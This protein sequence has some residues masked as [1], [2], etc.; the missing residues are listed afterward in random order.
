VDRS[1]E[2]GTVASFSVVATAS[3]A[4]LPTTDVYYQWQRQRPGGQW[5]LVPDAVGA[6]YALT[7]GLGDNGS[8]YRVRIYSPGATAT[9]AEVNLEVYHIN[10][11]PKYTC[12]PVPG[13]VEDSGAH[14]VPGAV[15][16]IVPHSIV[17]TPVTFT[18]AFNSMPAG[19]IPS[20]T[21][22]PAIGPEG[23]L[24]LTD[25]INSQ[26]NFWTIPLAAARDFES[27]HAN[28]RLLI[29]GVGG[30]DGVSFNAGVDVGTSFTP[31]DGALNG[32]SVQVD[33]YNN[34]T[35]D[36]GVEVKWNGNRIAFL[37]VGAGIDGSGAPPELALARFVD[38]SV[39]VTATGEVTFRYDTYTLTAQIPNYAG[40]RVNQ[41][42]FAARTGGA[43]EKA[44]IDDVTVAGLPSDASSSELTQVVTF[45][46]SND[47]PSL[48]TA[49]P[50]VS[51]DGTLTYALAPNACGVA[52]V[53]VTGKDNGG[54]AH[55]GNDT[56]APCTLTINVSCVPD[57]P[58]ASGQ[59]LSVETGSSVAFQLV[60]S[61]PDS[62]AL[63][64]AVAQAPAH[65]VVTV[66]VNT[67]AGSYA[68]NA[69]YSGPDSFTFTVSDGTCT[70]P[71]ATVNI[72]VRSSN[73]APIAKINATGLTD[74]SPSIVNPVLISGNGSNACL[75]LD[76][77]QSTDAET[78]TAQ[79]TFQW[80][81]DPSS[82]P[83][84]SGIQITTC[85][86]VGTHTIRLAV[87]DPGNLT[88][89]DTLTIDVLSAGE[90]IE[91]LID[92]INNSTI[93]RSNKRPFIASLKAAEASTDRG[94]NTSA[95]NQLH[96]LQNKLRAQVAKSDPEEAA[97]W[98]ALI[99]DIIDALG[100]P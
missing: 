60:G 62:P 83:F 12:N 92:E 74:F 16:G 32:L 93:A 95:A 23:A 46:A 1:V 25:Q 61:D 5:T 90:A 98:I 41:Y 85:L 94:N 15:S 9:S 97:R 3:S 42:V 24:H 17:R 68:P 39:D 8:K 96:A 6:S 65:G 37:P 48:F 18:T 31:E 87:T 30:A 100:E 19:T 49:Q 72:T 56:G 91:E 76:G 21:T 73:T 22:P 75:S 59:S 84:D 78:P 81:L 69:G 40:L 14:T 13:A 51:S 52:N 54:A 4:G 26:A 55:G 35:S 57:C 71:A 86:E 7:T 70:S 27:F 28:W 79:L 88:G 53:T 2:E 82:L 45:T 47:N 77:L 33:T 89:N 20:G 38:T 34:G 99:Q 10:T 66:N 63:T 80:F 29:E 50:A 36:A 67:G 43:N 11:P 44:W 58:I 64:Y